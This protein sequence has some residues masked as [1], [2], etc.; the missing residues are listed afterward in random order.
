MSADDIPPKLY[1]ILFPDANCKPYYA[2]EDLALNIPAIKFSDSPTGIVAG[3]HSGVPVPMARAATLIPNWS[4]ESAMPSARRAGHPERTFP[5][6]SALIF[7][8][9]AWGRAQEAYGEDPYLLGKMGEALVQGVQRHMMAC[10]KH[11]A[12][13]SMENARFGLM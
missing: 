5:A 13:N 8:H 2:G 7:R 9:P 10:V 1:L 12:A 6:G 3:Y 11:F 4:V